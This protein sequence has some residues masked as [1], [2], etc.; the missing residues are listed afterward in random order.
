ME[1]IVINEYYFINGSNNNLCISF[2]TKVTHLFICKSNISSRYCDYIT[3][4]LKY[5]IS[6]LYL[7]KDFMRE[8]RLF[9]L[10]T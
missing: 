1:V 2:H 9:I 5:D 4:D 6:H 7:G 3:E 8:L 10:L